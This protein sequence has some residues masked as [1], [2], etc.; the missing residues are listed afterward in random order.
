MYVFIYHSSP[1]ETS[2]LFSKLRDGTLISTHTLR[3]SHVSIYFT[4]IAA[5][6][7]FMTFYKCEAAAGF[8]CDEEIIKT[9]FSVSMNPDAP[10][11]EGIFSLSTYGENHPVNCHPILGKLS[12]KS[13]P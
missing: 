11:K 12:R 7:N 10:C 2:L 8:F 13:I 9:N 4:E 6:F 3:L 1:R 5:K